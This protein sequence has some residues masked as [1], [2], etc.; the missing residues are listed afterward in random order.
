[1]KIV[2]LIGT[3]CLLLGNI[4]SDQ[5]ITCKAKTI[6]VLPGC[7]FSGV[8]I[9]QNEVVSIKTDPEDLDVNSIK[10]V[11]FC[12]SSIHSVPR[13]VFTKFPNMKRFYADGQNIQEITL[14]TFKDAKKLEMIWLQRNKLTFL[15]ADVFKGKKFTVLSC[16]KFHSKIHLKSSAKSEYHLVGHQSVERIASKNV[17][18]FEQTE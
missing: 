17:F 4:S 18:T 9:A 13:E 2:L 7:E 16:A 12:S 1:M 8:T 6:W 11:K 3:L 14:D 15:H 5:T 10:L